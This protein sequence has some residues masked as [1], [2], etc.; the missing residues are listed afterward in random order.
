MVR[1]CIVSLLVGLKICSAA[2][3]VEW[4]KAYERAGR[5]NEE[6]ELVVE[7]MRRVLA[8]H[9]RKAE[10]WF[11]RADMRTDLTGDELTGSQAYAAKQAYYWRTMA[12]KFHLMWSNALRAHSMSAPW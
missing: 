9:S 11:E 10:W 6:L 8:F 12:D 4:A 1:N 7:E 2:L 3:R 5:W